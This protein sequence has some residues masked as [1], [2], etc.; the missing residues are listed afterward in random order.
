MLGGDEDDDLQELLSRRNTQVERPSLAARPSGQQTQRVT[1]D[2]S[3]PMTTPAAESAGGVSGKQVSAMIQQTSKLIEIISNQ[4][5]RTDEDGHKRKKGEEINYNPQEPVLLFE[6][7]YKIED[8][9]H[10]KIDT[11]LRQRL[12]PINT[13]PAE[14]WVKGAFK[15][16]DRPILGAALYLEHLIPG[17]ANEWT[18]CKVCDRAAILEIKNFLSKNSGVSKARPKRLKVHEQDKNDELSMGIQTHWEDADS[19]WE[20]MDAGFNYVAVEFQIRQYNYSPLAML[21]CLH[22]CRNFC[23]VASSPRQ[24]STLIEG[25]WNECLKYVNLQ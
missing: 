18:N 4:H 3:S 6:E 9:G 23:G 1:R 22:E 25:F 5:Q 24:Q 15:R 21:R 11:S 17:S 16:V 13:D 19:V 14:W 2:R 10:S 12:R 7:S 20:A 8:D